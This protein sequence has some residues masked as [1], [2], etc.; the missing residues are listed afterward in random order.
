MSYCIHLSEHK[1]YLNDHVYLLN[2]VDPRKIDWVYVIHHLVI[3]IIV[4]TFSACLKHKVSHKSQTYEI[5]HQYKVVLYQF[6]FLVSTYFHILY[7]YFYM[8]I[9]D[10]TYVT[11]NAL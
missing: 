2:L 1:Y 10:N 3:I 7:G 8:D 4:K 9:I 6:F 11:G 5:L